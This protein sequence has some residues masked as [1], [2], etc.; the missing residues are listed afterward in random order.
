[1][2]NEND[3]SL[4]RSQLF[5]DLM[6]PL[7]IWRILFVRHCRAMD[8]VLWAKRM[9]KVR[10]K[11]LVSFISARS[12]TLNKQHLLFHVISSFTTLRWG[13]RRLQ[14]H[15]RPNTAAYPRCRRVPGEPAVGLLYPGIPR[16]KI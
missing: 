2:A 15:D 6:L 12:S 1:M 7:F 8:F 5:F 3:R 13:F 9:L 14:F 4:H 11:L 16:I 10:G